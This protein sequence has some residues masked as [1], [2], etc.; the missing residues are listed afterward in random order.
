MGNARKANH[1]TSEKAYA[2]SPSLLYNLICANC[3]YVNFGDSNFNE[4]QDKIKGYFDTLRKS[5][6]GLQKI[7]KLLEEEDFQSHWTEIEVL[8]A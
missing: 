6:E 8:V 2:G 5:S 4:V 7:P 3:V 1:P